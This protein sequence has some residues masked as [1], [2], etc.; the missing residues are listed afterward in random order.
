MTERTNRFRFMA[1]ALALALALLL[2][3]CAGLKRPEAVGQ[4][5]AA[6]EQPAGAGQG[7]VKP[8]A[9]P[10]GPVKDEFKPIPGHRA[11]NFTATDVA[12]GEKVSLA[13]LRGQVVFLNFWATWCQPCKVEMP[14]I[15]ALHQEMGTKVRIVALGADARESSEKLAAYAKAMGLTFPIAYDKGIA[16][17]AYQVVGI[18][19]SFFI[20]KEGIIRTRHTGPMKLAQMKAY[21]A[22]TEKAGEEKQ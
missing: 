10:V 12:T 21:I 16:M 18:P 14:E 22:D 9:A 19:T 17:E 1:L 11:A 3:G 8:G 20:D 7:E 2:G 15:E 5:P 4:R 6:S 13:D